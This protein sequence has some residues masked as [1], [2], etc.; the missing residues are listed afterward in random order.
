MNIQEYST[1]HQTALWQKKPCGL[2]LQKNI[3]V[4]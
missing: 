1:K 2:S 4:Q 3:Y